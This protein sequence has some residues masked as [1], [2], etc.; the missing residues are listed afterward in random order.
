M[1][2]QSNVLLHSSFAGPQSPDSIRADALSAIEMSRVALWQMYNHNTS[3]PTSVNTTSPPNLEPQREALNLAESPTHSIKRER[4]NDYERDRDERDYGVSV[5]KKVSQSSLQELHSQFQQQHLSA[6]SKLTR[7][8]S[9]TPPSPNHHHSRSDRDR[10]SDR[11]RDRDRN[12]AH[13]H[14]VNT[15]LRR[16]M[17][18]SPPPHHVSN[19]TNASSL[20]GSSDLLNACSP[21]A[22]LSGMQFKLSSRGKSN[23]NSLRKD[24]QLSFRIAI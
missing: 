13:H 7:R 10:D 9:S 17:S 15:S 24:I 21:I 19:G 23:A 22:L 16:R 8:R 6:H 18:T 3:P 12:A 20:N 11:E 1:R 2:S 5:S 14:L 4:D